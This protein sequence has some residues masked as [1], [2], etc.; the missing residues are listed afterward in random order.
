MNKDGYLLITTLDGK[1]VNDAFVNDH[2]TKNYIDESGEKIVL[3][4]IVKKYSNLDQNLGLQIDLFISIFMERDSS[5]TEYLVLPSFLI[6]E[7]KT[8][9]NMRLV[10][11]E[12]F[13]NL[14]YVYED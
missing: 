13:Q 11:T 3:Y 2:I 14:Y 8:K 6:N 9:C 5:R 1:A 7:L 12:T 10:E 4:D